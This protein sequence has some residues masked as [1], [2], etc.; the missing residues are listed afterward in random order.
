MLRDSASELVGAD[1]GSV[2]G[3]IAP[4][5]PPPV[6]GSADYG[7]HQFKVRNALPA[8]AKSRKTRVSR[9]DSVKG[10]GW[11]KINGQ[12]TGTRLQ[13]PVPEPEKPETVPCAGSP[14]KEM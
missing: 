13:L 4:S 14:A 8:R 7:P 11:L 6:T 12:M 5:R 9:T 3:L 2:S 1:G 10:E